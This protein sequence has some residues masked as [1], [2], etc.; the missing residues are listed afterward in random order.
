MAALVDNVGGLLRLASE[1]AA[2]GSGGMCVVAPGAPQER[3][4]SR[5]MA[6]FTHVSLLLP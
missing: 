3:F 2:R 4:K 5:G 6:L 1:L